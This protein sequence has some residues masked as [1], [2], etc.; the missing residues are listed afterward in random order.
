MKRKAFSSIVYNPWTKGNDLAPKY[1]T[2]DSII[3]EDGDYFVS[4]MFGS[5]Y[6]YFKKIHGKYCAFACLAG[7]TV[8]YIPIV[9]ELIATNGN[10]NDFLIERMV[11]TIRMWEEHFRMEV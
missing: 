8:R 2:P 4:K 10:M 7:F 6:I 5:C 1:Y 9:K 11:N 3:Y